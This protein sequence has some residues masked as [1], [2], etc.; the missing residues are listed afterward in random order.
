MVDVRAMAGEVV[1]RCKESLAQQMTVTLRDCVSSAVAKAMLDAPKSKAETV[2][3]WLTKHLETERTER[4]NAETQ[5]E[6][7]RKRV[8]EWELEHESMKKQL[9][10]SNT[11][12]AEAKQYAERLL[13]VVV[14]NYKKA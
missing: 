4:G 1:H 13:A 5:L 10:E 14:G 6:N 8:R 11:E 7:E 9:V 3:S 12:T 2:M